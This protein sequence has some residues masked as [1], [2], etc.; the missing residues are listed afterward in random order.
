MGSQWAGS[1]P[2]GNESHRSRGS[3]AELSQSFLDPT[4][5]ITRDAVVLGLTLD[6]GHGLEL[7]LPVS[8]G[9]ALVQPQ[10][11]SFRVRLRND[12]ERHQN[13]ADS[14]CVSHTSR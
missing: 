4:L 5:E 8:Q 11:G 10:D 1:G 6:G 3:G 7:E 9:H 2:L 12:E 13:R 14:Y